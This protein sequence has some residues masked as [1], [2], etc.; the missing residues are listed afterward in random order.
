MVAVVMHQLLGQSLYVWSAQ[1]T[2]VYTGAE[3]TTIPTKCITRDLQKAVAARSAGEVPEGR[4]DVA[5]TLRHGPLCPFKFCLC[6]PFPAFSHCAFACLS[7]RLYV[8]QP[9][10]SSA[11]WP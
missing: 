7:F 9:C 2:V 1:D 5:T 6:L 4:S 3:A 11:L 8:L 10:V